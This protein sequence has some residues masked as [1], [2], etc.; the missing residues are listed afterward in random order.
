MGDVR[1]E[2]VN[3]VRVVGFR[4]GGTPFFRRL[5]QRYHDFRRFYPAPI[6]L[7]YLAMHGV[8]FFAKSAYFRIVGPMK[9]LMWGR[10]RK[11]F[12]IGANT[13]VQQ[14]GHDGGSAPRMIYA[15]RITGG[16]GDALII[17]RLVR[18]LQGVLGSDAQFDVYFQS[19]KVIEPF[20]NIIPGFR[21]C[22]NA[23][24]FGATAPYYTFALIAN[25]FI[26]FVDEHVDHRFLIQNNPK[27][28]KIFGSV[29][30]FRKD[31]DKY[32]AAHPALDGAFAD[33]AVR[34]GHKRYTY[35]HEMVGIPY[36]GDRLP[37][38]VDSE[39]PARHGLQAGRYITVHDGWD[40]NFKMAAHRPTKALPL[41][42]WID[43]VRYI[44]AARPDLTI[45]QLGGKVGADIPGVDLNLR[46]K[47][48]FQESTSIL[49]NSALHL[50]S[51]SGLVHLGA[52]LGIKS[53]VVF[54]PTNVE[55]FGY[56][57]N[58]NIRPKECGNCWWSTDT[59]MDICPAGYEKPVCTGSID[60]REIA[61]SALG[62]LTKAGTD[63]SST[64]D[65][66]KKVIGIRSAPVSTSE[67]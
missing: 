17:A 8:V 9:I 26:T 42:T 12:S 43:A 44:K 35:L 53:V 51:E 6:V 36:G 39:V 25:Q 52:T 16:L 20:F 38:V 7:A 54:G 57:Q 30:A 63:N 32:I 50:D 60:A 24:S 40:N 2:K 55:W 5:V 47:L 15:I 28:L 10:K 13:R 41:Q 29:S 4:G 18:D 37:L 59:W 21:E 33:L 61:D 45:V 62:L 19:P 3:R 22:I 1:R 46:K 66:L 48:S 56:P 23:A 65:G 14:N 11:M 64:R 34:G 58:A 49:A 27:V 67:K 31:I